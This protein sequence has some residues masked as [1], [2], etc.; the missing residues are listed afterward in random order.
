MAISSDDKHLWTG[1]REKNGNVKQFLVRH[2]QMI[3]DYGPIFGA[4]GVLSI[5]TT[6][7]NKH[8]FA[9]STGGHLKHICL[10]SQELVR[11][12]G[13]IHENFIYCL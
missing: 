1:G 6:P 10:D 9:G 4:T 2:G 11:D 7:D 12:Y 5:I 13:K 3:K 8:L